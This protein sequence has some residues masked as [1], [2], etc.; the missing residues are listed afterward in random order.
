MSAVF[1]SRVLEGSLIARRL[2]G[3]HFRDA[4]S[5]E[6][7]DP[8]LCAL[9]Y[10]LK[11]AQATPAWVNGLMSLRNRVVARLGLKDLGHLGGFNSDKP[12]DEYQPGDRIGIFTLIENQPDAQADRALG[13]ACVGLRALSVRRAVSSFNL[14]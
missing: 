1:A 4:W 7:A 14:H 9:E 10:F 11:A 2:P 6:P 8:G 3:A 12:L 5:V 13:D